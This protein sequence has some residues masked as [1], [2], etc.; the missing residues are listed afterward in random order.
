M[1]EATEYTNHIAKEENDA[2]VAAIR[3]SGKTEVYIPTK[4]ERDAFKKALVPVHR[5]MESR[6]GA[7]LIQA[8]YK[9]TD[10]HP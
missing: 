4:E 8:L 7:D 5:Q 6:I 3:K 1:Q 9:E 2:A 10:F